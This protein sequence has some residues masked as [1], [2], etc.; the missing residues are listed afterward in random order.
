MAAGTTRRPAFQ[1]ASTDEGDVRVVAVRGE[2]DLTT[3][4]RLAQHL[5]SAVRDARPVLVDVCEVSFMD[6][7]GIHELVAANERLRAMGAMLGVACLPAGEPGRVLKL[8]G[9][10]R[11]V[12]VF[13]SRRA[14]VLALNDQTGRGSPTQ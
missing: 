13:P 12:P 2:V 8:S 3:A 11:V 5:A 4:P 7:T 6:S 1:V 9:V 10:E 14:G